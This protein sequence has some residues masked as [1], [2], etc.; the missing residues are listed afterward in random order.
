MLLLLGID[1][2]TPNEKETKKIQGRPYLHL[3]QPKSCTDRDARSVA[4]RRLGRGIGPPFPS[5]YY[6]TLTIKHGHMR[7][8]ARAGP[9]GMVFFLPDMRL[10]RHVNKRALPVFGPPWN[11]T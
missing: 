10:T 11:K 6:F 2:G 7:R 8:A 9:A 1:F 5:S 4:I 3:C